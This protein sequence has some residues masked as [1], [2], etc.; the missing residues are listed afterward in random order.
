MR[1]ISQDDSIDIPYEQSVLMIDSCGTGY[2]IF[3]VIPGLVGRDGASRSI[4]MG[5]FPNKSAA[6]MELVSIRDEYYNN[7][8]VGGGL[9]YQIWTKYE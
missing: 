4:C 9:I 6:L 7:S 3:A 1:V 8:G 2:G 5:T